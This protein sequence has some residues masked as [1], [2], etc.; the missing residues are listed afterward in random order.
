MPAPLKP[1]VRGQMPDAPATLKM[2]APEQL[3]IRLNKA[4]APLD[5]DQLR[6][7]ID[8]IGADSFQLDKHAS[9]YRFT[10]ELPGRTI[11]GIGACEADAVRK[12]VAKIQK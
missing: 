1:V 11:E 7:Q 12:A 10:C 9:G 2:P 5:W 6:Q 3:G 8:E 4:D